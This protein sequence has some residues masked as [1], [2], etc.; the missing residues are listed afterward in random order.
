MQEKNLL[1]S[2]I[3]VIYVEW[4]FV[5]TMKK[6][7]QLKFQFKKKPKPRVCCGKNFWTIIKKLC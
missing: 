5:L 4:H 6:F 1:L 2:S 3:E 7:N